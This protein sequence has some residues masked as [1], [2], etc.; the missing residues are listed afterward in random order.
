MEEARI[1]Y[2]AAIKQAKEFLIKQKSS[3]LFVGNGVSREVGLIVDIDELG[4][5]ILGKELLIK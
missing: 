4:S 3:L 2:E 1:S 5:I